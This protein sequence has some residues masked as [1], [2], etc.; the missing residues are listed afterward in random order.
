[1][2]KKSLVALLVYAI[3]G[4]LIGFVFL[5]FEYDIHNAL[6]RGR[7]LSPL[8]DIRGLIIVISISYLVGWAP[9]V[10]SGLLYLIPLHLAG[11]RYIRVVFSLPIGAAAMIAWATSYLRDLKIFFH[12]SMFCAA[13]FGALVSLTCAILAEVVSPPSDLE[14]RIPPRMPNL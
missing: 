3:L 14:V 10:K 2:G 8:P 11:H 1:M 5:F 13:V 6:Y 9:S 4:P 12:N 7:E